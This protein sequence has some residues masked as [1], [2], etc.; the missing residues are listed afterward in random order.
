MSNTIKVQDTKSLLL[1]IENNATEIES[2][3][4]LLRNDENFIIESLQTNSLV[5]NFLTKEE[6][7]KDRTALII[8][9]IIV[10]HKVFIKEK[11]KEEEF[12]FNYIS[13]KI[14]NGEIDDKETYINKEYFSI[15]EN[16]IKVINNAGYFKLKNLNDNLKDKEHIVNLFCNNLKTNQIWASDRIKEA[17]KEGG[18]EV[19]QYV[20]TK[21]FYEKMD[22]KF[23]NKIEMKSNK[24]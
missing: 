6:L 20:K 3:P 15:E 13:Q 14:K 23:P 7:R 5:V 8:A 24:I 11:L 10:N 12:Y 1:R 4:L 16:V 22:Q 19:F 18:V 21:L 9:L 2:V 17:A